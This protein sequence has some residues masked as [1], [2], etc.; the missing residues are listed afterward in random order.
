MTDRM[1][2]HPYSSHSSEREQQR[3][4]L[5][6]IA[7]NLLVSTWECVQATRTGP[8]TVEIEW[9][10]PFETECAFEIINQVR[11]CAPLLALWAGEIGEWC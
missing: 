8:Q 10:T 1:F 3:A 6:Q 2:P 5:R 7:S 9:V 11:E 4:L